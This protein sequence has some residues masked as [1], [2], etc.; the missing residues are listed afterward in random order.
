MDKKW[1]PEH[2]TCAQCKLSLHN[3]PFIIIQDKA[4]CRTD[5]LRLMGFTCGRCGNVIEE[6][7]Y[8]IIK[9]KKYH[10]NCKLCEVCGDTLIGK[11]YFDLRGQHICVEHNEVIAHQDMLLTC[12][13]CKHYIL[14]GPTIQTDTKSY[15]GQHFKCYVCKVPLYNMDTQELSEFIEKNG[16]VYCEDC[17]K[18]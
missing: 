10:A 18:L 11:E 13:S 1:H 12:N 9:E 4:Y 2:F 17:N 3:Q 7:S 6:E 15:H 5:Y 14:S 16:Q 8:L